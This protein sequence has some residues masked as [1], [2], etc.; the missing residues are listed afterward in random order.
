MCFIGI[1]GATRLDKTLVE[2]WQ[3][4][5]RMLKDG[6]DMRIIKRQTGWETGIDGKWRY[7]LADP[8]HSTA[9]I[10]DHVKKHFGEP[11]N[12]RY[13]MTDTSL[14]TAY[15]AFAQL[16]LYAIYAPTN[17]F[18]GYFSPANYGMIVSMGTANSSFEYQIEGI[19]LHEV[20]HLI[21]IE[22]RFAHGGDVKEKNYFRIAGEVE[23][24]NVCHRHFLTPE[25]R[26]TSLRTDTQDVIDLMQIIHFW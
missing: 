20:Q 22:E 12:I 1:K 3:D 26:R 15:P 2:S 13:C 5:I 16:Q 6:I 21:Q 4:A 7:E 14:L 23:A 19:L 11:L 18:A 8:F 9:E 25:Q 24:R 10:E 17:R